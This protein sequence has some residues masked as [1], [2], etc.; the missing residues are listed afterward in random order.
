MRSA[1]ATRR[2]AA[3]GGDVDPRSLAI[4]LTGFCNFGRWV[5]GPCEDRP[6]SAG[7]PHGE[8]WGRKGFLADTLH[9]AIVLR[10]A[11]EGAR[12]MGLPPRQDD[13]PY[14]AIWEAGSSRRL[15]LRRFLSVLQSE[16]LEGSPALRQ[17]LGS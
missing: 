5:V 7:N 4:W 9:E 15:S 12:V 1:M 6:P 3:V 10:H 13:S 17:A 8:S 16:A 14:L 11:V 2:M